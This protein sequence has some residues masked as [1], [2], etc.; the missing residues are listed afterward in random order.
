VATGGREYRGKE[1]GYGTDPRIVTGQ[2]FETLLANPQSPIPNLQLPNS[3]VFIQCVGPADKYCSRTCCAT[4]IK[5]ALKLKELVPD[6]QVTVL[7]KDLRT[8]GFKERLYTQAREKGILFIR[9]DDEHKPQVSIQSAI[10]NP[11]AE[12]PIS[13]KVWEPMLGREMAL[14][15]DLLV[16]SNPTVPSEGSRELATRLKVPVDMDGFFLEAHVKLRPV[17]FASEGLFMAG[18][19]HYPKFLDE[20]IIQAQ[21]AAARAAS[22][23]AQDTRTSNARVA[24]VD[25]DKCVGCLTCVRTCPFDVPKIKVN[26]TGVGGIIGAAFIEPVAC[27]GCGSCVSEC[28]AKAIQLMHYTDAQMLVKVDALFRKARQPE[29]IPVESIEMR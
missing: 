6:A 11:H 17:D 1:Y 12:R 29:L 25:A 22:I 7:F 28:P 20:S 3:V 26:L 15:P 19:A 10:S 21:A 18:L 16:L 27:Q 8:F 4:A 23:L 9:Y 14:T 24:V 2:E 13:I 5:N